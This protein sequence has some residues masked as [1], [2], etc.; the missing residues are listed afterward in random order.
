ML[1]FVSLETIFQTRPGLVNLI[2][3]PLRILEVI[4]ILRILLTLRKIASELADP[5]M[6]A[7]ELS[8]PEIESS[9]IYHREGVNV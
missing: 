6:L 1:N 7:Q 5:T 8:M 9:L 3:T 4:L 2:E